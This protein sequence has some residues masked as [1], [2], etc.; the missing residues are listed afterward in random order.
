MSSISENKKLNRLFSISTSFS[1]G[2]IFIMLAVLA[3]CVSITGIFFSRNSLQNFYDS[4]SKELSEFS[5]TITMFFSE[6]EGKLNVFAESEEVKAADSTIHSFVNESGEIKIPD[7]RKSLTEQRIRAL[8]KKFAEHDPSIAE[9][10]LGT[11]WGG[12]ATNF[13]SSM[14]G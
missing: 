9:I 7:Y 3:L 4:A 13:D 10:Y 6:K 8:C 14:Q 11:R 12:Y 5:D 1:L 2:A